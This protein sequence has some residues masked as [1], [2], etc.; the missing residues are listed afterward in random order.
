MAAAVFWGSKVESHVPLINA[1]SSQHRISENPDSCRYRYI[2][3]LPDITIMSD[4]STVQ[5]KLLSRVTEKMQRLNSL[6]PLPTDAA[7]RLREEMRLLHTYHS[8][9]IEGN[10]LSLSETK[11]VLETGITIGGKTLVEHIEATNNAKAFDLVEKIARERRA[12]DHVTIQEV[13]EVVTAGILED[14]GRYRTHNV[15]ITGA[16]KTPPDWSK[17][18]GSM[19]ELIREV[20]ENRMHPI[21]TAAFLHHRFVE[22]R[23]F[24]DGNGRVA[25]LLSNLYLI[26]KGY[27]PVVVRTE[28]RG[29]YYRFLRS[30]D[31]GDLVPFTNFIAK[32]VD[33]GATLY[34][35]VFGGDDE[36]VPLKELAGR[37]GTPY[38][39]E[40]LNLLSRRGVLD[41]VKIRGVWHA[42][43]GL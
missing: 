19:D 1:S 36:L 8:N 38:S 20:A 18:V 25:R 4:A 29:R 40:Y 5:E 41:A 2:P 15:R 43:S 27:P 32:A 21:D 24:A 14:A 11:L 16:A 31:A 3:C 35:S 42:S 22:I 9:A 13:H 17:V 30:A 10:T 39:Q 28:D 33:E 34:L 37:A 26:A 7:K 6:R 12:I 23:P